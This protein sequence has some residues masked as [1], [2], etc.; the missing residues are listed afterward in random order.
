[1]VKT[2]ISNGKTHYKFLSVNTFIKLLG[3]SATFFGNY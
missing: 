2:T 3:N 1:M